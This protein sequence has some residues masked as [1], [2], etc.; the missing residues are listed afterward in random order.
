M[1]EPRAVWIDADMGFDDLAAIL[2]VAM[3]PGWEIAGLSLVAGNAPLEAVADNAAC[4]AAYFGWRWPI[5]RGCARSIV[6]EAIT[7]GYVLGPT[8]MA[9]TGRTLPPAAARFA[10][11]DAVSAL[12]RYFGASNEPR[13]LL[14]LG[15]L[16]N[17]ATLLLARPQL[18]PRI[19]LTWMGGSL[20]TGNHT[21]AAEFNAAVDPEAVQIVVAA[22]AKLRMIGLETC[23][24]VTVGRADVEALRAVG[25]DRALLLADL[26][27]AY[28]RIASPDASAPMSLYDPTAAA[29]MVEPTC[30]RWEPA[31]M[32]VELAGTHTRG[33]TVVERR[34]RR[35]A[36]RPPN[37][38]VAVAADAARVRAVVMDALV[39]VSR[40]H[41]S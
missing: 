34:P 24:Q 2:T 4:S 20:G 13:A 41:S 26:L 32:V 18:A 35:L 25:T 37:V 8:G 1:S 27:D 11:A 39:G 6:G 3:Q 17:V 7:A 40:S 33:M 9:S 31:H 23:R 15:P 29:G 14:A 19:A 10:S 38:E 16:T 5:H 36:T 22:G 21:A 28:V 12:E 30:L